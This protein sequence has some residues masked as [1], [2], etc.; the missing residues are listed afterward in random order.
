MFLPRDGKVV[1][2]NPTVDTAAY[3]SGD[4]VFAP[5]EITDAVLNT[6]GLAYLRTL[7]VLDAADIK[8]AIDLLFFDRDPGSIAAL[9]AAV[10]LSAT[11]LSYLIGYVVVASADYVTITV[12]NNAVAVKSPGLFLPAKQGSKSF[13]VAGVARGAIDYV[14]ATDLR[15]KL[16]LERQ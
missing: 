4:V 9:N 11:Q 2:L 7:V 13:W 8:G 1:D 5:V 14:A 16:M 15:I 12:A 10:V 6:K 3:A